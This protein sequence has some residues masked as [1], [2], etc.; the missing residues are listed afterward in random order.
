MDLKISQKVIKK[1]LT[2]SNK[3]A[4]INRHIISLLYLLF[5]IHFWCD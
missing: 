4:Q 2:T 5:R 1:T 3:R